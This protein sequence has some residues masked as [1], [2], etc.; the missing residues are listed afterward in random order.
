LNGFPSLSTRSRSATTPIRVWRYPSDTGGVRG[1]RSRV[2]RPSLMFRSPAADCVS[3]EPDGPPISAHMRY[4]DSVDGPPILPDMRKL[5]TGWLTLGSEQ[6]SRKGIG[7]ASDFQMGQSTY[8]GTYGLARRV[9]ARTPATGRG[10]SGVRRWRDK[11]LFENA[12]PSNPSNPPPRGTIPV[13]SRAATDQVIGLGRS[14]W[15]MARGSSRV[16]VDGS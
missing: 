4:L 8:I 10:A 3:A 15:V 7:P 13:P 14:V 12:W 1:Q 11:R 2:S 16:V 9:R 6:L 5:R